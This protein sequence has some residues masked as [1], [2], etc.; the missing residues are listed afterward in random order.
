MGFYWLVIGCVLCY[1]VFVTDAS[2]RQKFA[3]VAVSAVSA[4]LLLSGLWPLV[5][6]VLLGCVGVFAAIQSFHHFKKV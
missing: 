3:A 5:G 1:F 2:P 6:A 4:G